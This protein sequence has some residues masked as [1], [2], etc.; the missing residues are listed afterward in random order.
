MRLQVDLKDR[1]T[2]TLVLWA[3]F[4]MF[5]L[6]YLIGIFSGRPAKKGE[7]SQF[8][9]GR[10]EGNLA[11]TILSKRLYAE[12]LNL[13]QLRQIDASASK[14][15]LSLA[16]WEENRSARIRLEQARRLLTRLIED[17]YKDGLIDYHALHFERAIKRWEGVKS[18]IDDPLNPWRQKL[19]AGIRSA[20]ER[21][22]ESEL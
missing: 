9:S 21:L 2:R 1:K 20:E 8:S 13:F 15:E 16:V 3:V 6:I 12:G 7:V 10:Q 5:A 17:G 4:A 22:K 19:E 14:W 11:A 18:L